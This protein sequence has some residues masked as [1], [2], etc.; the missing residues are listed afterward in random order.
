MVQVMLAG[1]GGDHRTRRRSGWEGSPAA[2]E[3][4]HCYH[5]NARVSR[6]LEEIGDVRL[7]KLLLMI[8]YCLQAI[9]CR[10]RHGVRILYYVPAPGK[11]SA[12]FRDWLVLAACRPFFDKLVLHWHSSGLAKWL[13]TTSP[14]RTRALT[15]RLMKQADLSIVLSDYGR[16]DAEKL[17]PQRVAIV[18]NGIPDP[19]PEFA[20][21]ILP[22]RRARVAARRALMSGNGVPEEGVGG[23]IGAEGRIFNVLFLG[24]CTRS[25][26][27]FE[28]VEGALQ[29]RRRLADVNSPILLRL[30]VAGTFVS[31]PEVEAFKQARAG[32]EEAVEY[33][34]FAAGELKRE[35]F[36]QA[37]CFLFPSHLESFGLVLAEAMAFG[38]PV[39]TTRCGALPEVLPENAGRLVDARS[40][41]QIADALIEAM[42]DDP[43]EQMR[44]R[45]ERHYTLPRHL[46]RLAAALR[47][48]EPPTP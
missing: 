40:P 2:V 8:W 6:R 17:L 19:C 5:V 23:G 21:R 20:A 47:S 48:V 41:G 30:R 26:G 27:L 10:Y 4:I 45:F 29:A 31:Q 16:G 36:E 46:A 44:E 11:Q 43:F 38:L 12:L 32:A 22:R 39:V 15:Y 37:D 42:S 18:G 3:D 7:S 24:H 13:E 1:F 33:V 25:K 35:L 9:W 28:A 14:I 34:G